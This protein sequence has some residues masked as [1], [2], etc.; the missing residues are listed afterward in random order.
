MLLKLYPKISYSV[1]D[2]TISITTGSVLEV[3]KI[4][5]TLKKCTFRA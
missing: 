3:N 1:Q 5:K 4:V 2:T